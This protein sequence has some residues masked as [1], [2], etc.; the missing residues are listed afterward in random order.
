MFSIQ[1][2]QR[3]KGWNRFCRE[4]GIGREKQCNVSKYKNDKI[5]QI[6]KEKFYIHPYI[7][8]ILTIFIFLVTFFFLLFMYVTSL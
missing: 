6:N 5:K 3:T 2:N 7:E 1:Q 4:A 8:S